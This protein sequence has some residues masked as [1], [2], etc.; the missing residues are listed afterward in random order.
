MILDGVRVLE[1]TI[2]WAGPLAGRFLADRGA[3]VVHVEHSAAR[4]VGVV[5]VGGFRVDEDVSDWRWG[6][7]PGPVFRSG[8]YPDA[9]PGERPWNRQ[10]LFNKMQRNKLSL[11]MD[12]KTPEGHEALMELIKVSDVLLDNFSPRGITSMGLDWE[13]VREINPRLIRVSLSGYGHTGPDQMRV[14]WGPNL[15]AHSGMAAMTGYRDSD[16]PLKL[17]PAMPDPVGGTHAV[18]AMLAALEQRERTG[19]GVFIDVSQFETFASIGG[20]LYLSASLTGAPPERHANRSPD[21]APQGVYRCEG[22]DEW[23][24]ISVQDD[25]EWRALARVLGPSVDGGDVYD[26][27]AGRLAHQDEL[28]ATIAA[29]TGARG[30]HA[31][32]HELQAAGVRAGAVLS[33]K[34]VVEDEHLAARGFMRDIDTIDV[35][36]RAF[37]GFPIHFE[38]PAEIEMKG[39]PPLGYDNERVLTEWLGYTPEKVREL[40]AAGVLTDTAA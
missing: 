32:M 3:E 34:D 9:D 2:A 36:V 28:D 27:L 22:E 19:E 29:W 10:G 18:V 35:G 21:R 31:A 4:G 30:K 5:G 39:S 16:A 7:M 40:E 6:Q 33:N 24:A 25:D 26:T 8:I 14:S 23:V 1:F 12:V 17:G 13:A 15:E 38:D 37:P 11:C 20:E